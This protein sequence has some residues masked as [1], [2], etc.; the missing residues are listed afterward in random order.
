MPATGSCL[1][2]LSD[3][4][5]WLTSQL[6]SEL[7]PSCPMSDLSTS[8]NQCMGYMSCIDMYFSGVS[9]FS[10]SG[11]FSSLH[12]TSSGHYPHVSCQSLSLERSYSTFPRICL[13]EWGMRQMPAER[14]SCQVLLAQEYLRSPLSVMR[15]KRYRASSN[16]SC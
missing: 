5:I 2:M 1:C 8:A 4:S 15:R 14:Q 3:W 9:V 12:P 13:P 16:G 7:L 11:A 6:A 10:E